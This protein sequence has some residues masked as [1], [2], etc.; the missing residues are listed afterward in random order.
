MFRWISNLFTTRKAIFKWE[1]NI[2][3]GTVKVLF[4]GSFSQMEARQYAL[5]Q[6]V[7]HLKENEVLWNISFVGIE[8]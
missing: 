3:K 4:R 8:G 1:S 2:D 6:I 5:Q 7:P